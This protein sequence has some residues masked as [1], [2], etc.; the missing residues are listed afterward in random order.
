MGPDVLYSQTAQTG[1]QLCISSKDLVEKELRGERTQSV[2]GEEE[3][4]IINV[5]AIHTTRGAPLPFGSPH[6]N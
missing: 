3:D 1:H 4:L 5:L 6:P 2:P